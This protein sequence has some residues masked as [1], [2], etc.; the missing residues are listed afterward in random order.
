MANINAELSIVD[1][2]GDVTVL[3]PKT[4]ATNVFMADGT[5]VE[6]AV[7]GKAASSHTHDARYYTETEVNNLLAAKA[8]LGVIP[9]NPTST[10]GLNIWLEV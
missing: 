3:Y 9:V 5:T 4:Y 10:S 1:S 8:N 2:N 6:A 7:N